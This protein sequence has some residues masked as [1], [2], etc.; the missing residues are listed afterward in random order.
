MKAKE[1]TANPC[2]KARESRVQK[3]GTMRKKKQFRREFLEIVTQILYYRCPH[4]SIKLLCNYHP[5]FH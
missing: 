3:R 4:V 5:S 1:K 2:M